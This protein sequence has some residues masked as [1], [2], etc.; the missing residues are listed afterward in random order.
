MSRPAVSVIIPVY[1][2]ERVLPRLF[3]RLYGA[4]DASGERYEVIFVNDGSRD[5]SAKLLA[6]QYRARPDVNA[7]LHS[8]PRASVL[9]GLAHPEARY[10][11]FMLLHKREDAR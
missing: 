1:N 8:H 11:K 10:L 4:L 3:E 2:E 9:Y 6:D 7:I 5:A